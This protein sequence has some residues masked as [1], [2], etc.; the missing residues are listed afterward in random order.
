M[1]I[2]IFNIVMYKLSPCYILKLNFLYYL[3]K[4]ALKCNFFIIKYI[5]IKPVKKQTI[6]MKH[7][8][9]FVGFKRKPRKVE[10]RCIRIS[11]HVLKE[12]QAFLLSVMNA[13]DN[14]IL[15]HILFKKSQQESLWRKDNFSV[16]TLY[17]FSF[18][19]IFFRT[20]VNIYSNFI[21]VTKVYNFSRS[22][23]VF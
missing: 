15:R 13:K 20:I 11:W 10:I 16:E 4:T 7:L 22:T 6:T 5:E 8:R 3:N 18:I 23:K 9:N 12:K 2:N 21:D 1:N 17:I 14:N 19:V